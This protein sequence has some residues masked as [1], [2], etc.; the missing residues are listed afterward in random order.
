MKITSLEIERFGIWDHLRLP[1][2]SKGLNVFYGP[3]EA[4]KTTLMQFIRSSLYGCASDERIRY[5]QMVLQTGTPEERSEAAQKAK[6]IVPAPVAGASGQNNWVGGAL[7]VDSEVGRHR[8]AR[9]YIERHT[10]LYDQQ[11]ALEAKSGF[12]AT[13]GLAS[14]SG[15][16]YPIPGKG[17]AESLIVTGPDGARLSDYFVKTLV[18]NVDEA[19][20]NNVFAIGLDELQRLSS[21][22]E[23]DAA[24]MLY[25]LSVGVDRV[26]L[27]AILRQIVDER[28][29]IFDAKGTP[30]ILDSL[31]ARRDALAQRS[32]EAGSNLREYG[33]LLGE[34]RTTQESLRQIRD[35]IERSLWQKRVYEI[36]SALG[37]LWDQRHEL[38]HEI[39]AMGQVTEVLPEALTHSDMYQADIKGTRTTLESLKN[40]YLDLR[41]KQEQLAI[42]P[43]LRQAAPRIELLLEERPKLDTLSEEE[44]AL[45]T[46]LNAL[47]EELS[48]EEL[49]LKGA[50]NGK[51]FLTQKAIDAFLSGVPEE[52]SEGEKSG[53][54]ETVL[55]VQDVLR[56][57]EDYRVPAR[58][59]ARSRKQKNRIGEQL[60]QANERLRIISEKL[61]NGLTSRGQRN[62]TE[63]LEKTGELVTALRRRFDLAR[64]LGELGQIRKELE[65]KNAELKAGLSL[66]GL[67]LLA[68]GAGVL[69]GS[70]LFAFTLFGKT[71]DISIGILGLLL[72]IASGVYK[73]TVEK[74][75]YGLLEENQR[76]LGVLLKQLEQAKQ[77]AQTIDARFPA[78]GQA[79]DIRL[80]KAQADLVWFEKLLPL[81]SQWKETNHHVQLLQKR[82]EKSLDG[83]RKARQEWNRWLRH[84]GLPKNVRPSQVHGLFERVDIAENLRQQVATMRAQLELCRREKRSILDHLDRVLVDADFQHPE[85]KRGMVEVTEGWQYSVAG[86]SSLIHYKSPER[87]IELLGE[88][89]TALRERE[90]Q[91]KDYENQI[92]NVFRQ[93]KK[94]R[95]QERKERQEWSEF[96][97]T[98]GAKSEQE[99]I[100]LAARY[101]LFTNK[102]QQLSGLTERIA[103][104]IGGFCEESVI[105]KILDEPETRSALAE[106]QTNLAERLEA[107]NSDLRDKLEYSGRL[108]EQMKVLGSKKQSLRIQFERASV[109]QRIANVTKLWQSRAVA[110]LVMEE[111]RKAYEKERQ[112]ET[113]REASDFLRILTDRQYVKIWT[114]LGEDTLYVDAADGTTM[115][116]ADLSRGTR[117]QLF[118]A[119]RL[120]LTTTFEKH[121]ISLPL[122]LDDVL[123]NFDNRR[124]LAAAKL[125]HRFAKAGRQIFLFTCHEHIC[126]IFLNLDTPVYVLP[127]KKDKKK[128][129]K[130]ILPPAVKKAAREELLA[131]Q[132]APPTPSEEKVLERISAESV[133]V[134]DLFTESEQGEPVFLPP[135]VRT[136]TLFTVGEN[137]VLSAPGVTVV[138]D[139][140]DGNQSEVIPIP[141][142]D[143]SELGT[144]AVFVP[145]VQ[146][147]ADAAKLTTDPPISIASKVGPPDP[148]IKVELSGELITAPPVPLSP[149]EP[150][151][152]EFDTPADTDDSD[153][154]E[155][156]TDNEENPDNDDLKEED[157]AAGS[158]TPVSSW[159]EVFSSPEPDRDEREEM[160]EFSIDKE[161]E[162]EGDEDSDLD[163]SDYEDS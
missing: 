23:T 54:Q 153:T 131:Q 69:V 35:K 78:P 124:A 99:L 155:S 93:R 16:F 154:D 87:V 120:A 61:E 72:A 15:R 39:V 121:G 111:I 42:D 33:R 134:N 135:V 3:N 64:R 67:P 144:D 58:A 62:L 46:R 47:E 85:I 110:S 57:V 36:S 158:L 151:S 148:V 115:D 103:T 109:D 27:V 29:E 70:L 137:D 157:L 145:E 40:Q 84:A 140:S 126:K 92:E 75:N 43:A 9:R 102:K 161:T 163:D 55:A 74:K 7:G 77:E 56:E 26:S 122:I 142:S 45:V 76:Q 79:I 98:Y 37:N 123:V 73:A 114:P 118:I 48:G 86:K 50:K 6:S 82:S 97:A 138:A 146:L 66:S 159:S 100:D 11:T 141:V 65:F 119:I 101:E 53:E 12:I 108:D 130:V 129:F 31:L 105:G 91:Y 139:A 96:L 83:Y 162:E 32:L 107:L 28:N 30:A 116:V 127:G 117:E 60:D 13:G 5:I 128:Q 1:R 19:T 49:R 34:Q 24:Q 25:R 59:I 95:F 52:R 2:V 68:V 112:P 89:L 51:L 17:I 10:S 71:A 90:K 150:E 81:D 80:Q 147:D 125:L 133:T 94:L 152:E 156:D 20:F 160:E 8:L 44:S 106:L 21:L 136:K 88:S 38:H 22:D 18:A 143:K 149:N 4:G 132:A 104:G 63:A 41:R 113:L 14:W